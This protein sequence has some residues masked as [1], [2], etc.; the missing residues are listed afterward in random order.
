MQ[1]RQRASGRLPQV[2]FK[3]GEGLFNRVEIWTVGWQVADADPVGREQRGNR[4][5]FMGGK[6]VEDEG[7]ARPQLRTEHLPEIDRKD[8]GIDGAFDQ[9]RGGDAFLA[10]RGD[11]GGALPVAVGDGAE[12]TLAQRTAAV[13]AGQLGVQTRLIDKDQPAE[14]PVRLLLPPPGPGGLD[15]RPLLL[16]GARRFFYSSGPVAPAGATRP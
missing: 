5:D 15:V 14:I 12:A 1:F 4:L 11:E 7:V 16:G 10:Q 13:V 2:R 3:F 8:L 6:V 9:E